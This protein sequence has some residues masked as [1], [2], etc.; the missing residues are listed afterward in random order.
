MFGG[1]GQTSLVTSICGLGA[2]A[3]LAGAACFFLL[4][5][6][7]DVGTIND[8][9]TITIG[10]ALPP[11]MRFGRNLNIISISTLTS[12]PAGFYGRYRKTPCCWPGPSPAVPAAPKRAA[13]DR[14]CS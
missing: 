13:D 9:S 3:G 1:P 2:A 11:G 5:A 6:K 8:S 4:P 14:S 10:S 12:T 7:L